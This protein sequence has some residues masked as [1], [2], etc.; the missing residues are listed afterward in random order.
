MI[1]KKYW[2]AFILVIVASF[3]VLGWQGFEIYQ[4]QPPIP[5]QV[6][7]TDGRVVMTKVDIENG[8]N[9]WQSIGGME[10]GTVW[11][12]GAYV[13][14]DWSADWLHRE[15]EFIL[16]TWAQAQ[17]G[18]PF[19]SISSDQQAVFLNHLKK[20]IRTNTYNLKTDQIIIDPVRA[21]AFKA[22]LSHY[23]DVFSKGRSAY[24]IPAGAMSDPKKLRQ[25]CSFFF[26]TSWAASTDRPGKEYTYTMNWP[27]EDLIGNRP[28]GALIVWTGVSIILLLAGIGFM[29]WFY[30]SRKGEKES[31]IPAQDPFY[32]AKL[33]P[34]QKVVLLY[35]I[36][37]GL[38]FILQIICGVITAH[39]GVEG[40][41]FYGIPL[42]KWLPYSVTRTW[43]LQLGLFW[44]ATAWLAS[45]L[46]IGPVI[47]CKEPRFQAAGVLVLLAALVVIVFGSMTGEWMSIF[48]KFT[49]NAWFYWGDQGY[50]YVDLGRV[51]QWALFV[52]LILWFLLVARAIWPALTKGDDQR[53]LLLMFVLSLI[54]IAGF[55]GAGLMWGRTTSLPVMEYWRWWVIHLWVEGFFEVFATVAISFLFVRM[56]LVQPLHAAR[57]VLFASTIF[58]SGGIIGTLHHLYFSGTPI[59]VMAF[60]AVF[61][62]LEVVPLVLVGFEAWDNIHRARDTG[63]LGRYKWPIYFFVAVS[64]W[65]MVGAG[66]FGFMINPPIALYYMQGLNTTLLHAHA[67][68]FGVYGM[69]GIGLMLF[70]L[71]ICDSKS[72]WDGKLISFAFW[73]LNIGLM[74]MGVLSL[75]PVGLMQTWASVNHGYWYARSSAFLQTPMINFWRWMRVPGDTIF[76]LGAIAIIV[77]MGKVFIN[78]W[79]AGRKKGL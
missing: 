49:G 5:K 37:V 14:P 11:G 20:D 64:F 65:N 47:G 18:K 38:L 62:A 36:V 29:V 63:W 74:A 56:N 58:L 40:N 25:L 32:M 77:F 59:S 72:N 22:N 70:C 75:L 31:P 61:S 76:S 13:A 19:K 21:Q 66:L 12:H 50:E 1:M 48:H 2:W 26:W 39:Y 60:G 23:S 46:F 57:A 27:H 73:A 3:A 35:F 41:G 53:P 8:Q 28:T 4:Y 68:L 78:F 69:L 55:Y 54:A 44:I 43:H 17:Y 79:T 6:V 24:A 30:G 33:T 67:A 9:V 10:V 16:N 42:A 34:S 7:T 15:L 71:R 45:G 51:W 52:G